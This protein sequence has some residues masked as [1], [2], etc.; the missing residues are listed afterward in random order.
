MRQTPAQGHQHYQREEREVFAQ[1]GGFFDRRVFIAQRVARLYHRGLDLAADVACGINQQLLR[2]K[3]HLNMVH[4]RHLANGVFHFARAGGAVHAVD[5]PAVALALDRQHG[6]G[7]RW[8]VI[9]AT[10]G[11]FCGKGGEF[12]RRELRHFFRCFWSR[13]GTLRQ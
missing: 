10:A 3:Q 11:L 8:S 2:G 13:H 12:K 7:L 1:H 6:F 5:H 9:R 4:P